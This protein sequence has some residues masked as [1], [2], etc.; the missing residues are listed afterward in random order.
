[1]ENSKGN[2]VLTRLA[3][4]YSAV[5]FSG[6]ILKKELGLDINLDEIEFLFNEISQENKSIDKPK[7]FLEEIL[8]NLDRTRSM[9]YTKNS[10]NEPF[11]THAIYRNG[12]RKSTRLNSS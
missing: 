8:T 4:Y 5:H 9:I 10:Q 6:V 12:D 11:E 1:M 7:Q 2:E 3:S